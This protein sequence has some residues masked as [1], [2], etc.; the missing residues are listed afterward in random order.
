MT[1][2]YITSNLKMSLS[3]LRHVKRLLFFYIFKN[4]FYG[5]ERIKNKQN[6][7]RK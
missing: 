4:E 3:A 6:L 5:K 7:V 2:V 1:N